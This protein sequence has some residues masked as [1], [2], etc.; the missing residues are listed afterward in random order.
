V[1]IGKWLKERWFKTKP[2]KHQVVALRRSALKPYYALL[3][4]QGTG[5]S[6]VIVITAAILWR[7]GLID[8]L[9]ILAPKGV[10]P[11]W[12]NL[13]LPEHMPEDVRYVAGL[14]KAP[15]RMSKTAQR[16]LDRVMA[17]DSGALRVVVMNLEAFG[18]TTEAVDFA[19]GLLDGAQSAMVVVDESHRIKSPDAHVTKRVVN[20]R[21][22]SAYRRILTGTVADKPFDVFSQF[23]FLSPDIID[24]PSFAAF[25]AEYAEMMPEGAGLMRHIARRV[26]KVW[27]GRYIDE[28]TGQPTDA[29]LDPDGLPNRKYMEPRYLPQIV[30]TNDDGTPRYKNLD[31]LHDLLAPHSFRVLKKDC[32]DL[33]PKLYSRYYTE[34]DP[35]RQSDLYAQIRDTAR[36]EWEGGRVTVMNRLTA[37]LRLQ[38]VVCGYLPDEGGMVELFPSWEE[39]PRIISTLNLIEDRPAYERAIIWCRF[40]PDILRMTEALEASYGKRSVVQFYGAINDT[41]RKDNVERFE[42]ERLTIKNGRITERRAVP[43]KERPRFMISQQKAG[44]LGQTWVAASLS[45]HYSNTFSLI[46][47]LQAEDRPHRIGQHN[48]VDYKD[49]EAE[50]TVDGRIITA[51]IAKKNVADEIQ[52]DEGL[53]WLR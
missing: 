9:V 16:L 37:L 6:W 12:V 44:G 2:F 4:E 22:R 41:K 15:S 48:P 8:T 38:Q 19:I 24:I 42:G 1:N 40:V 10:A 7:L 5:K 28:I 17:D 53:E 39:N 26:P 45:V 49:I 32:L 31:K 20:L 30:A 21:I 36:V 52:G 43:E 51:L 25:R 50:D 47:R 27:K 11:G 29:A 18:M 23:G 35:G 14:W 33:P 3:M 13:Q 46:D 34:L